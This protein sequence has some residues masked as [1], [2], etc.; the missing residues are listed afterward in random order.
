MKKT[1]I[2]KASLFRCLLLSLTSAL[3]FCVGSFIP[4]LGMTAFLFSPM[5]LA[6]LGARENKAWMTAGLLGA[7]TVLGLFFGPWFFLDFLLAQG[8]LCFGLTLPLGK[9]KN[10]GESLLICIGASIV[11][12]IMFVGLTFALTGR[13]PFMWDPNA[14]RTLLAH[15]YGGVLD[16]GTQTAALDQ[17]MEQAVELLPYMLPSLILLS[18][19]LDSFLNYRLC[20][21][22]QRNRAVPFP[23][24]PSFENWRFP[25][26]LLWTLLFAFALPFLFE[27]GPLS[28][29]LEINLKFLVSVFFFLQVISLVWWWLSQRAVHFLLRVFIVVLLFL[30]ILGMWAFVLGIGDICLDFRARKIQRT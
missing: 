29:M 24:L 10:G 2:S 26:S 9:V 30:P 11:S 5:P 21:T 20:E 6:L 19:M 17:S 27:K 1:G 23:G 15:M 8:F 22:L 16:Q 25:K 28:T 13:N 4:P 14:L 18:S 3:L 12:K 7:S